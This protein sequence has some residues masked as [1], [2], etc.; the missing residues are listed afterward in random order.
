MKIA[1]FLTTTLSLLV[2]GNASAKTKHTTI[3]WDLELRAFDRGDEV[4]STSFALGNMKEELPYPHPHIRRCKVSDVTESDSGE[5]YTEG[6]F[7]HCDI[8]D[9]YG[10]LLTLSTFTMCGPGYSPW[11]EAALIFRKGEDL[12]DG[13]YLVLQCKTIKAK[14]VESH[15]SK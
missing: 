4:H 11:E 14:K 2:I 12:D 7:L 1:L 9:E 3:K 6:R 13:F 15:D 5:E 8:Y 10:E